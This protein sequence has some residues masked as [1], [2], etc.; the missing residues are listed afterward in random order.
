MYKAKKNSVLVI[1]DENSN[2]LALTHILDPDYTVY[3]AKSGPQGI[4][5]ALKYLPDVILLDIVMPEMDGYAVLDELRVHEST[6]D[7]PIIFVTGLSN[8]AAEEAGLALGV[9]DYIV[10]PF[11]TVTVKLRVGNQ[12]R[13]IEQL[14]KNEYDIAKYK[15]ANDALNIALWDMEVIEGDPVNPNNQLIFSQE[16]RNL[17]GFSDEV[18][19]PNIISSWSDR[20]HPDDKEN[21][22]KV[23]AERMTDR[24]SRVAY[25]IEYRLLMKN[26]K[27]YRHFHAFGTTQ[28]DSNGVP[29]R[30]AGALVDITE[31]KLMKEE[32]AEMTAQNEADAH[33][34]KSILDAIPLPISVT[35]PN[36]KWTFVNK[37]VESFLGAKRE[38][39]LG[40]PCSTAAS[41]IC[42]T[43][44]CGIASVKRGIKRISFDY[45]GEYFQADIE[46]LHDIEGATAGFVE[47]VQDVTNVQKLAKQRAEAEMTN[48]AKSKFLANMSHEI[49]TPMNAILG[50]TEI[51]IQSEKNLPATVGEGLI[52]IHNSCNM[53]L[54]II[55]DILDFS[56][57]EAGKLSIRSVEYN[58]ASLINDSAQ[59]NIMK[60]EDKNIDFELEIDE[61]IPAK[62]IGDELRIKQILNNL[63]SNAFK[64]TD[65]G[66]VILSV[67]SEKDDDGVT[68]ILSVRD[69]GHGMTKGQ[70]EKLF[71]DYTRFN[72]KSASTVEGTGLGLSITRR[73]IDLM[74][75][76]I[77]VESKLGVGS[78]FTVRL[79]HGTAGSETLGKEVVENLQLFRMVEKREKMKIVHEPMP[80]GKVLVVDDVEA[81]LYVAAGLMKPYKLQIDTVLSGYAAI[82]NIK[83]GKKYDIIFMDHMMPKLNGME[84]TKRLRQLGY[85]APIVAQTANAMAGQ[86][87]IFLQNGFDDFIAK[88]IDTRLLHSIICKYVRD[89]QPSETVEETVEAKAMMETEGYGEG[90]TRLLDRKIDGLD[91]LKGLER[92]HNDE[93]LYLKIMHSYVASACSM[94]DSITTVSEDEIR[95][96]EIIVHGMKGISVDVYAE[97]IGKSAM[98]LEHAAKAG[99]YEYVALNNPPFVKAAKKLVAELGAVLSEIEAE[100]QKPEK[101]KPDTGLLLKLLAA[102]IAYDMDAVDEAMDAIDEY[103][104]TSDDGLAVLLR[105]CVNVMDFQQIIKKLSGPDI[106]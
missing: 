27:E 52:K 80:Y 63:L 14:R 51:M 17:L 96:Y 82:D 56:K 2:I 90:L 33:W 3:A 75:G 92:Y 105:D 46:I 22:L 53:L 9:V 23:F 48:R 67:T 37:A 8:S 84:T 65:T 54:G 32:I 102:C 41:P 45:E 30:M 11:S 60:I 7:I 49:R 26:G 59:L 43:E 4:Q 12:I 34:Y 55:N 78:I 21:T 89:K 85:T 62:L 72:Q 73:L 40:K 20:L 64:Y 24:L 97:E 36:K 99:N 91:I 61:N 58:V 10:K 76:E 77:H 87:D 35:D 66:K 29:I 13:L 93:E 106:G 31:E 81:N 103:Q 95:D 74:N 39:L 94:L 68:L 88:P 47:V 15:L 1:D 79:P 5:A 6:R 25:N 57:I 71:E 19:F 101:D 42:N 86:A 70:V 38:N 100:N 98:A 28:R 16:F 83:A 104:Y 18:D 44:N 69:T 50:I